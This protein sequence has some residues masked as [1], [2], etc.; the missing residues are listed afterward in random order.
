MA[1]EPVFRISSWDVEPMLYK[2]NARN[3]QSFSGFVSLNFLHKSSIKIFYLTMEAQK[4]YLVGRDP[5]LVHNISVD[6][7]DERLT[8]LRSSVANKFHIV[9]PKG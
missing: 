4:F 2:K 5:N 9:D 3:S 7:Q 6:P 1:T 8:S